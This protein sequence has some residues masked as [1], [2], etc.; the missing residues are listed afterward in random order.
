MRHT[1]YKIIG[2]EGWFDYSPYAWN[3]SPR[4]T[5]GSHTTEIVAVSEDPTNK[6]KPY[7]KQVSHVEMFVMDRRAAT[8]TRVARL[9]TNHAAYTRLSIGDLNADGAIDLLMTGG[10]FTKGED[11][12]VWVTYG[13][14]ANIPASPPAAP[15]TR[16]AP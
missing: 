2:R 13:R 10:V 4:R 9:W 12:K 5:K 14:V 1:N 8:V 16:P 6:G 7:S 3:F 15:T 11:T